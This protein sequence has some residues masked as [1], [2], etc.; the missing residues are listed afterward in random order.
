MLTFLDWTVRHD[1][2]AQLRLLESAEYFNPQDYN[3]V[4]EGELEKV[5]AR[6]P[7][8][9]AREQAAEMKGYDWATYIESSLRRA[10]FKDDDT[11]QEAFHS[12]VVKLL[13]KPGRLFSGWQPGRHGPLERRFRRS[14]WNAIRNLAEKTRNRRRWMAAVDPVTMAERLPGRQPYSS[15]IDEFRNLVADRLGTLAVAILDARLAGEDMKNLVGRNEI[16]TP[17][18]YSIKRE[19]GEIKKL[20]ERF[21]ARLGNPAFAKRVARA[22]EAE[23]ETVEKRRQTMAARQAGVFP[24]Q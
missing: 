12:I 13:V 19:T 3:V 9:E 7:D 5:L 10:G 14:V 1:L 15:L 21:A 2:A 4:F 20:A 17:S 11:L 22:M 8:S 18:A 24:V 16:G 23:A 6:I